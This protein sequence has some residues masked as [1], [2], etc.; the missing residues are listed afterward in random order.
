MLGATKFSKID[1]FH[2]KASVAK[3]GFGYLVI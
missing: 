2:K 3:V 1:F